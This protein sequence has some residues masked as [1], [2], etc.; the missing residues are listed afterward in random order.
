MK[1]AVWTSFK[2]LTREIC[3]VYYIGTSV[4]LYKKMI[5]WVLIVERKYWVS[6]GFSGREEEI[7]NFWIF[8]NQK[9]KRNLFKILF[10]SLLY[11]FGMLTAD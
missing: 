5:N 2:Q 8:E 4:V 9:K 10:F 7:L 1:A 11:S 6:P 3:V